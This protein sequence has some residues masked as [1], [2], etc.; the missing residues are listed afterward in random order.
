MAEE[1]AARLS[2]RRRFVNRQTR[3][4]SFSRVTWMGRS[5]V[6]EAFNTRR[7]FDEAATTIRRRADNSY[8]C[9]HGDQ[10]RAKRPCA[11]NIFATNCPWRHGIGTQEGDHHNR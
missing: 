8:E 11:Q 7:R 2:R 1:P 4:R 3:S 10:S 6:T 9:Y 5:Q